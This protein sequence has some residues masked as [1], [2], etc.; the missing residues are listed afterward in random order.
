MNEIILAFIILGTIAGNTQIKTVPLQDPFY[1]EPVVQEI[2]EEPEYYTINVTYTHYDACYDCCGK[3]DG[4]TASGAKATA[5]HTI[6][7]PKEYP[8][9][10]RVEINGII[11]VV[12][13]RGGSV[14]NN[15]FDI[16]V[17]S[18]Q[19]AIN[20]GVGYGEAKIYK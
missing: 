11:Y 12:E 13:D 8:F 10:T 6:A 15:R 19:E 14:K 2:V 3:T 5:N 1:V 9:G 17:D 18:H 20:R 16:Y 4:I 7:A